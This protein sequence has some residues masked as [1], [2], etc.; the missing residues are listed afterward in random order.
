M[1]LINDTIKRQ[2]QVLWD[3]HRLDVGL[4]PC[5]LVLALGSHDERVP[6]R[7]AQLMLMLDG[8]APLLALSGGLGK[9]T[10]EIWD[11]AEADRFARIAERYG[12]SRSQ[13][14]IENTSTNTG[15]NIVK[16]RALLAREGIQITS[17][18]LVTKPYMR[19]RAYATAMQQWPGV[20]WFVTSP[21]ESFENYVGDEMAREIELMVGDLQ[22]IRTYAALGYQ[23]PQAMPDEVWQSYEALVR[24]GFDKYVMREG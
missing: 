12:V 11:E 21:L 19:R 13:M 7:A 24:A 8:M 16:T 4:E 5:D 3:Y 6:V 1:P 14:L 2:A 20:R 9:V 10:D 22:R 18:I 23:I 15:E 17:G